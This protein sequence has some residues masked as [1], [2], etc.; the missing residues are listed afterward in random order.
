MHQ[1][2]FPHL[3]HSYCC[4]LTLLLLSLYFHISQILKWSKVMSQGFFISP[5]RREEDDTRCTDLTR[6]STVHVEIFLFLFNLH[7]IK[8]VLHESSLFS[9]K[10]KRQNKA[11]AMKEVLIVISITTFFQ[12]SSGYWEL[13]CNLKIL[14]KKSSIFVSLKQNK[15]PLDVHMC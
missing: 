13:Q 15:L 11:K 12:L 6:R 14:K 1:T 2:F 10:K 9:G 7:F 8:T 3:Q 4:S 5:R